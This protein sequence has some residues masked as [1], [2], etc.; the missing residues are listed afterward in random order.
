MR[1]IFFTT[2]LVVFIIGATAAP[3]PSTQ[4][5]IEAYIV[6][7]KDLAIFEHLIFG[8][9][10]SITLAQALHESEYGQSSLAR[11]GNNHFGIKCQNND[12]GSV[13]Y[14]H[15][16]D[17]DQ[18][19][20][21]VK[22]AFRTFATVPDSYR[23]HSLVLKA[24]RYEKL[25]KF[26]RTDYANWAKGLQECGYATDPAYAAKLLDLIRKHNL[27][28]YDLP[29]ELEVEEEVEEKPVQNTSTTIIES[30]HRSFEDHS[31]EVN[32]PSPDVTKNTKEPINADKE[33]KF[34]Y[35]F[36]EFVGETASKAIAQPKPK[37]KTKAKKPRP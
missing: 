26:K 24:K 28:Q 2:T 35:T 30:S 22:S 13:L 25:F 1:K 17:V 15:D 16:D 14:R 4:L 29:D 37:S 11:Q 18:R 20:K 5:A 36:Y 6:Q 27:S 32:N 12:C 7:H 10:A 8:I 34:T 9:P 31:L 3:R 23:A 21:P 33:E 19:G